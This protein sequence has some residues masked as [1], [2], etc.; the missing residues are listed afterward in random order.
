VRREVTP[1]RLCTRGI[2]P[3]HYLREQVCGEPD[4][5]WCFARAEIGKTGSGDTVTFINLEHLMG[6]NEPEIRGIYI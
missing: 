3:H 6:K 4:R 2:L 1:L 5:V